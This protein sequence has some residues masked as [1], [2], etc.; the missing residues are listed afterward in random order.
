MA[1]NSAIENTRNSDD[2]KEIDDSKMEI[3]QPTSGEINLVSN[4]FPI[5]VEIILNRFPFGKISLI[6]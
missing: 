3:E 4:S 2:F 5:E 6:G 1:L